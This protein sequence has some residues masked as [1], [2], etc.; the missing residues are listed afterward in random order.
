MLVIFES[1]KT[2]YYY[3][4]Y[5]FE[6]KLFICKEYYNERRTMKYSRKVIACLNKFQPTI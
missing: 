6:Q 2:A 1:L 4:E 5:I 3:S